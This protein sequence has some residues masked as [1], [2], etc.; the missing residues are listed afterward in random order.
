LLASSPELSVH[1]PRFS[2][3]HDDR[4]IIS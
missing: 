4:Y 2:I 1:S 3:F